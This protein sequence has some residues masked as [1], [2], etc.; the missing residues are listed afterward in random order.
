MLFLIFVSLFIVESVKVKSNPTPEQLSQFEI[1]RNY[2]DKKLPKMLPLILNENN[3]FD[4][5][6]MV[7]GFYTE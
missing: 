4:L 1:L 2:E 7:K 5:L 6:H 3:T